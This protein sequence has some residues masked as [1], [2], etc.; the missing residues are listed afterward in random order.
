MQAQTATAGGY[1]WWAYAAFFAVAAAWSAWPAIAAFF[2]VSIVMRTVYYFSRSSS[3]YLDLT[4]SLLAFVDLVLFG[5]AIWR[6][7]VHGELLWFL[8][9]IPA[10]LIGDAIFAGV[11]YGVIFRRSVSE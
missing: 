10:V 4:A 7:Y 5:F 6:S 9:M 8:L 11:F 3:S 1:F 2:L